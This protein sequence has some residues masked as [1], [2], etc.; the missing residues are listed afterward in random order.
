MHNKW[1]T[2]LLLF[3]F[4]QVLPAQT[5][6]P[7]KVFL[8]HKNMKG[9]SFSLMVKEVS[10]GVT[11]YAYDTERE[12]TPA[13]VMKL[14]TTAT[15]LE[16]LG[17]DFR[18][19]TTLEFDG[20][21]ADSTL[22]G[23]LYIK[24]SG[25]PTL[26]SSHFAINRSAYTPDKNIFIPQWTSAL[27]KKG[28]R[29]ISGSVIADE[30]VFDTEGV[31]M[32]WV[33]EDLGSYYGAGCYGLN[34]FDNLFK[35]YVN[36]GAPRS[37]P[38]IVS[39]EPEMP[40]LRFHNY[41]TAASIRSDSSYTLGAPFSNDRYLYGI[42]PANKKE[43]LLRGDIPDPAL[44]LAQ[45][46]HDRLRMEGIR[47]EGTSTCHRILAEENKWSEGSRKEIVTT[48]SPTLRDIVRITNERS[49]NLYA[50]AL[51]KAVGLAYTPKPSEI[52]SSAGRGVKVVKTYWRQKGLNT[53]SL[54]MYDGNGIALA[55]K[56]STS[57]LCDL[58][59]YMA[60][61]SEQS[62]A[63]MASL[64]KAGIEGSVANFLKG[65]S[66]QGR[67]VLKSGAMSRVRSYAGYITKGDK[68][69]AVV[70][71]ANNFA[72]TDAVMRKEMERLL[73]SLF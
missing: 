37:K 69:Y 53:A 51:L 13:S 26:G 38:E 56:V 58:L 73:L 36:T 44:F 23:N 18:F 72:G 9:A 7:L 34:V 25:D 15:A 11:L 28:I 52:I 1:L 8:N 22:K 39:C 24:G 3:C 2:L 14:V 71:I 21:L 61:Q 63:F 17:A 62:D 54:W 19:P 12:L 50:D 35:L 55:D 27:H 16:L 29:S 30:S 31:S 57:F 60:T 4:A 67:T 33:S 49:H 48:Y 45:Y 65:S 32:K 43:Y 66:L 68:R 20:A 5:P 42:V 10:S 70:L 41:L 46:L 40:S 59:V 64:P 47:I 6:P